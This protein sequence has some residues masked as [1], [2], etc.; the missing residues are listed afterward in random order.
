M[1]L[2]EQLRNARKEQGLSID[3]VAR[4]TYIRAHF[5][6]SIEQDDYSTIP[7]S[8]LRYF[9]HDIAKSVGLDPSALDE[10]VPSG[11][12]SATPPQ[13]PSKRTGSESGESGD[14]SVAGNRRS[15]SKERDDRPEPKSP[16][17]KAVFVSP[18]AE[19]G[20][21]EVDGGKRRRPRYAPI[22]QGN[23]SLVRGLMTAALVLLVGLGIYYMVG[24]FDEDGGETETVAVADTTATGS[25][26][27]ILTRP[28]DTGSV[29]PGDV[30]V[31][32]SL[33]L[34]GRATAQVWYSIE[35]DGRQ[36]TGTLDSGDVKIWKAEQQFSVSLG[37]A[38]GLSFALNGKSLGVLGPK[39]TTF[40]RKIITADG[41]KT[42]SSTPRRRTSQ[43]RRSA[44]SNGGN[45]DPA[46]RLRRLE[47]SEP[48]PAVDPE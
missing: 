16:K 1:S 43:P 20:G 11:S 21:T 12:T 47:D 2:G 3:D 14:Q 34:E 23:P 4:A 15:E 36:E 32:D 30:A 19:S 44:E 22:E 45:D 8:R 13:K 24:G 26:T 29:E 39:G 28:D 27:R 41:V 42:T 6:E 37:N 31:G 46:T 10:A 35:M 9:V 18:V 17:S 7:P 25:D 33:V 40:R 48:R 38:G 5:I